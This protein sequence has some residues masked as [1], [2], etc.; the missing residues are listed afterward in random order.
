MSL[1]EEATAFRQ[2]EAQKVNNPVQGAVQ[3]QLKVDMVGDKYSSLLM[4]AKRIARELGANGPI[5]ID[6]VTYKM[7]ETYNV[8]PEKLAKGKEQ[9]WKGGVFGKSEWVAV[10]NRPSTI[11][12]S[13]GRIITMWA[14]KTW[15]Q[16]NTMN[17][18][19]STQSSFV[20]SKLF[21]D[22]KRVKPD[23]APDRCTW[24]IGELSLN[25]DVRKSIADA[26]GSLYGIRVVY[27]PGA[28]GA[29]LK[30]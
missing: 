23:T 14:L 22:F 18:K 11:R 6:D 7:A 12:S 25:N 16:N 8:M 20:L 26:Q 3:K 13:H 5:T 2:R 9:R 30:G 28:V 21:S 1:N 24:E 19:S 4:T 15:L 29:L 27:M 17:G 10:S